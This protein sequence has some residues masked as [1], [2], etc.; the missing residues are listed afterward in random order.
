M[1][2]LEDWYCCLNPRERNVLRLTIEGLVLT[3]GVGIPLSVWS[4][5]WLGTVQSPEAVRAAFLVI[6][7]LEIVTIEVDLEEIAVVRAISG[8]GFDY[9]GWSLFL[10]SP[11][12][13]CLT[14]CQQSTFS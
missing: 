2:T 13:A 5:F 8:G 4:D 14:G 9:V 6:Y 1:L 12:A 11:G 7:D 3:L 10:V